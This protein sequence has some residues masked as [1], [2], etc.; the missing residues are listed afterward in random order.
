[1]SGT[2]PEET[3]DGKIAF[4]CGLASLAFLVVGPLLS[5]VHR[6]AGA[7]GFL[8]SMIS[9][10]CAIVF[11]FKG[12]RVAAEL[13]EFW[14]PPGRTGLVMGVVGASLTLALVSIAATTS[15]VEARR[16]SQDVVAA[17][18]MSEC[19]SRVRMLPSEREIAVSAYPSELEA[20]IRVR[21][22]LYT[23]EVPTAA[24]PSGYSVTFVSG[25]T[26]SQ[27]E[28]EATIRADQ[29]HRIAFVIQV[30][31]EDAEG[32]KQGGWCAASVKGRYR[33]YSE[34]GGFF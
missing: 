23:R 25:K 31:T 29:L 16:R 1:M 9:G 11:T 7:L 26:E 4:R 34:S 5:L 28:D 33:N 27:V 15:L 14:K 21:F 30:P 13:P 17:R 18:A 2:E 3:D 19:L 22:D 12:R 32:R 6:N 10:V 20:L 24:R 8:A